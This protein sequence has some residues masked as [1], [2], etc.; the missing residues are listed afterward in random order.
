M[1]L[2]QCLSTFSSPITMITILVVVVIGVLYEV[3][4]LEP[5]RH[6]FQGKLKRRNEVFSIL[7]K[8]T[9]YEV[10]YKYEA[11]KVSM[12]SKLGFVAPLLCEQKY[13]DASAKLERLSGENIDSLIID[14]WK[15]YV[16]I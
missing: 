16:D 3:S 11:P 4:K 14:K 1:T 13:F 5:I 9:K 12:L 2:V 6:L 7:D 15:L 10:E 8:V